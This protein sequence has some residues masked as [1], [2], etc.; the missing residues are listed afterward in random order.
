MKYVIAG[1][2]PAAVS[3]VAGA[4]VCGLTDFIFYDTRVLLLFFAVLGLGV[5]IRRV[6]RDEALGYRRYKEL[7]D[8]GDDATIEVPISR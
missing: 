6:L 4:L 3:A 7:H 8:D 1:N 2:G 5:G